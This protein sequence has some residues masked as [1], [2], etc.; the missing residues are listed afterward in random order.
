MWSHLAK[1]IVLPK[2]VRKDDGV[3]MQKT[4]EPVAWVE[5]LGWS[6]DSSM[7][8]VEWMM[9]GLSLR[10]DQ[11]KADEQCPLAHRRLRPS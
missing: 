3:L 5:E 8:V 11:G 9:A 2:R 6:S 7:W 4:R 10:T 1:R